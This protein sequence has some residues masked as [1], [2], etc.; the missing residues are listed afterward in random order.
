MVDSAFIFYNDMTEE[1][2]KKMLD[3][4]KNSATI[5]DYD[6]KEEDENHFVMDNGGAYERVHVNNLDAKLRSHLVLVPITVTEEQLNKIYIIA[7][8]T[9]NENFHLYDTNG[10]VYQAKFSLK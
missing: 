2:S 1:I 9:T 7:Q 10:T 6:I 4:F 3:I 5:N 8:H